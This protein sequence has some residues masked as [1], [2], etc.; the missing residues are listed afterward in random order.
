MRNLQA[1]EKSVQRLIAAVG[2]LMLFGIVSLAIGTE[3]LV[4]S[5]WATSPVAFWILQGIWFMCIAFILG[6]IVNVSQRK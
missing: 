1:E 5:F 2:L 6:I 3:M 4:L